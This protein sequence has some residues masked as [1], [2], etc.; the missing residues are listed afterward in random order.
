MSTAKRTKPPSALAAVV[1]SDTTFI[2]YVNSSGNVGYTTGPAAA[3]N[4]ND[5]VHFADAR[6]I[7]VDG[8]ALHVIDGFEYVGAIAYNNTQVNDPDSMLSCHD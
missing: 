4:I 7:Q 5:Q 6:Q 3:A 2:F 1:L 8:S